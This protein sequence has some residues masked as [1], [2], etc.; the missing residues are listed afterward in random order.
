MTN[1]RLIS[2]DAFRGYTI[3]AMILV[4]HPGSW[5]HVYAPFS[6]KEWNG[7]TPTDLIFPFFIFIVGVSIVLA[8]SKRVASGT[9]SKKTVIKITSRFLKI[10]LVGI[11]LNLL[12]APSLQEL[13]IAG[14]LQRIA[15]V[16]LVCSLLFLFTSWRTWLITGIIILIGYWLAMVLVPTPEYGKAMLEPGINLA[17]RV[18]RLILPGSMWMKTWD[19]EG[20]LSTLP[21]IA[22]GIA[23]MLTGMIITGKPEKEHK[24]LWIFTAGFLATITGQAWGWVF[25]LNKSL[26]T[27]SY[28]LFTGG[29][30]CMT[31]AASMFVVD[32]LQRKRFT[33]I[34][35]VFGANAITI[36]VLS[37]LMFLLDMIKI[38]GQSPVTHF[39][40]LCAGISIPSKLAS[41]LYALL[42]VVICYIPAWLLYRKRIFIKL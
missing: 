7:V 10:F 34:G 2:L 28:V 36:Y 35:I 31:L 12:H 4:N 40:N 38:Q 6:H 14:V 32:I 29:L 20:I 25:P 39:M 3:A 19:P 37:E 23:G 9:S 16:F 1:E 33:K 13:R 41:L 22:T 27:S 26:W 15:V 5:D 17:A 24:I 30:A 21:A 11:F 42:I 18:D 8:Y